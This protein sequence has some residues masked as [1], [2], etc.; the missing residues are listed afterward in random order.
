MS[1]TSSEYG[2]ADL[3]CGHRLRRHTSPTAINALVFRVSVFSCIYLTLRVAE[4]HGRTF[5]S[6][7]VYADDLEAPCND[8]SENVDSQ[9]AWSSASLVD[10]AYESTSGAYPLDE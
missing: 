3:C 5:D 6:A 10:A 2:R 8:I 7:S 1:H 9:L 4:V